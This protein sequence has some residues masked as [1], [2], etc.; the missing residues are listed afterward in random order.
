MT[1]LISQLWIYLLC[2]G[3]LGL[4]LG[5]VIWGWTSR[6]YLADARAEHERERL[7]LQQAFDTE[8]AGFVDDRNMAF[9][10]RDDL[11]KERV[12][13]I[14]HLD[15]ERKASAEAKAQIDR[16]TQAEMAARGDFERKL[17]SMQQQLETERSTAAEA[18]NAVES[19]RADAQ[20]ELQDKQ[21]ALA[22][23]TSDKAALQAELQRERQALSQTKGAI[24]EVRADM[25]RQLQTKQAAVVSAENAANAA[26]R[27]VE[28]SRGE[29]ARVKT[30]AVKAH[31]DTLKGMERSLNEE[32]RAKAALEGEL[33]T[34]RRELSEAKDTIDEV[35]ADMNRQLQTKQ[36]ALVAAE[37]EAKRQVEASRSE[38]VSLR[39]RGETANTQTNKA[40]VEQVRQ[41]MQRK[42]DEQRRAT[43]AAEGER[44]RLFNS[45]REAK[46]EVERLRSQLS[47]MSGKGQ[48]ESAEAV[49]LRRELEEARERQNGLEAELARLRSQLNQREAANTKAAASAKFTTDAPRPATLF[50]RRPDVVDDLKEVKGIGPVMERILNENGCYHFKQLANFSKRDIEWIS[51]ALGSFPDRIERDD[52]VSQA[53]T[54][55]FKKYGRR[56]DVGEVRTLET[57]S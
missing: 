27:D 1:Y 43:A 57:V 42:I 9:G 40:E 28:S 47:A 17:T 49:R 36:A 14:G 7:S 33:R 22:K 13:L 39:A 48:G 52:W 29:L 15:G 50:D 56:H 53:Q 32:R 34:E 51:A 35:R 25:S 37:S 26:K 10:A 3:L 41:A 8:R 20:H 19:I 11:L 30:E 5:W 31:D 4:L 46:A 12:S 24:E 23:V 54:L 55:Y 2:S 18:K 21:T 45:E 6:R 16:L 44:S 38:I